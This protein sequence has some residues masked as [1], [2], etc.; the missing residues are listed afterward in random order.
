M[1]RSPTEYIYIYIYLFIYLFN[2]THAFLLNNLTVVPKKLLTPALGAARQLRWKTSLI[3][4]RATFCDIL[5][6]IICQLQIE[7]T[8]SGAELNEDYL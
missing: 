2:T 1:G 4:V 6:I 5:V 8:L 3:R 7:T